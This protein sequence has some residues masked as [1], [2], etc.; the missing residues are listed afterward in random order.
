MRGEASPAVLGPSPGVGQPRGAGDRLC[1]CR[2]RAGGRTGGCYAKACS[3]RR[4][5]V[6]VMRDHSPRTL[7]SPRRRKRLKPRASLI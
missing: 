5:W 1:V 3:L 6:R 2:L 4:L 7:A